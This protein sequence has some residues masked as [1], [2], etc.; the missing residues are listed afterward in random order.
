VKAWLASLADEESAAVSLVECVTC[1]FKQPWMHSYTSATSILF[2]RL[3]SKSY[4]FHY[5]FVKKRGYKNM[6]DYD[7]LQRIFSH[8]IYQTFEYSSN[9][10]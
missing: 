6:P 5:R 7:I 3:M 10:T 2:Y 4:T 1:D 8:F 9:Q